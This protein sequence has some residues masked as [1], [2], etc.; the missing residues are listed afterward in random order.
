MTNVLPYLKIFNFY[1]IP[2][3]KLPIFR[4]F[5]LQYQEIR[6]LS[7]FAWINFKILDD[8]CYF[9][10]F[11]IA[12]TISYSPCWAE[13]QKLPYQYALNLHKRQIS[14]NQGQT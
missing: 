8:L 4:Y 10:N 14:Y 1:E 2:K 13:I 12:D 7:D 3:P 5:V 6:F 9:I 11:L